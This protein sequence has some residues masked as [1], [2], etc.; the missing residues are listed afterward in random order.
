[1]II[2]DQLQFG[3]RP[4]WNL[5]MDLWKTM[6]LH[7]PSWF[8]ASFFVVRSVRLRSWGTPPTAV[9]LDGDPGDPDPRLGGK[10]FDLRGVL[11]SCAR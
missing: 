2:D 5:N 7:K 4:T 8:S 6:F 10:D 9:A 3:K 11:A 1:M